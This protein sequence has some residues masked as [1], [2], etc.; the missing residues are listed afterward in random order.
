MVKIFSP[1]KGDN[2]LIWAT[3]ENSILKLHFTTC[4]TWEYYEVDQS[5]TMALLAADTMQEAGELYMEYISEKAR[6]RFVGVC[7][8][9]GRKPLPLCCKDPLQDPVIFYEKEEAYEEQ[10]PE[11]SYVF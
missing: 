7:E 4:G 5:V 1:C 6:S 10:L 2:S 11:E 9:K 8:R 3:Y